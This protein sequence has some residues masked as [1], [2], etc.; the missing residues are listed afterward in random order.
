[1]R[2]KRL[3]NPVFILP[4][5]FL[6]LSTFLPLSHGRQNHTA[7]LQSDGVRNYSMILAEK[8]TR[9]P[10]PQ[11]KFRTYTGGWDITN[12]H[13]FAS[14]GFSGMPFVVMAVIWFVLA[15][16]FLLCACICCCCCKRKK[17][18][19]YSRAVYVSSLV[20]LILFTIGT[21]VGSS[22]MFR[23]EERFL[24]SVK[25]FSDYLVNT[26][27]GIYD[28]LVNIQN[29]LKS[30]KDI[31]L[32]KKY[33]SDELKQEVDKAS[34]MIDSIGQLPRLK[35]EDATKD[36]NKFLKH[37]NTALVLLASLMLILAF[38][39]FS[40]I[41]HSAMVDWW[42]RGGLLSHS[43]SSFAAYF[44]IVSDT[45]VAMDE[46]VQ[47]PNA[48]SALNDLIPCSD[49]QAGE[50]IKQAG[51]TV[52]TT[53]NDMLNQ[54]IAISNQNTGYNQS[55]PSVPLVCDP[56]KN[57]NSRQT[58]GDQVPLKYA[59][60]EWE[61]YV[62]LVS[63][64]GKC[65]TA[66]RLTPDMYE[67]MSKAVNVS[68]GLYESS[69]FL[70]ALVDCTIVEDAVRNITRNHCPKLKKYSAWVYG[71][72]VTATITV[73]FS[74]FFWVLHAREMQHRKYTKCINKGYDEAPLV[75]GDK[76]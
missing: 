5:L 43:P 31:V 41:L 3:L 12:K 25:M 2:P 76:L 29:L 38:L 54:I 51:Q 30:A 60:E 14:V 63:E 8:Q 74:L 18:Y 70:A 36:I 42:S 75:G 53:I 40:E 57:G 52:T 26:G 68:E 15:G 62:C 72:L 13:Y 17:P 7:D 67:E 50:N 32:N 55:G 64:T 69:H 65:S 73:M 28:S 33:V 4:P 24:G 35:A 6:I 46:W 23:G 61:K 16:M 27:I 37:V 71:G 48:N 11:D 22:V 66:G 34:D 49:K 21:I 44:C 59:E 10:D 19:G 56:Y 45:C 58:C 9:R 47:N 20:C 39:G 1:M